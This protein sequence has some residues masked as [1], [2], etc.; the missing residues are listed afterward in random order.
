LIQPNLDAIGGLSE[1]QRR[2]VEVLGDCLNEH[3]WTTE[4]ISS[5]FKEASVSTEVGMR[6]VYRACY[7][8]FMGSERGPRLAPILSTCDQGE[9]IQLVRKAAESL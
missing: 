2:V 8:V 6:D 3:P 4:G 7:S 9:M 1:E 5:A